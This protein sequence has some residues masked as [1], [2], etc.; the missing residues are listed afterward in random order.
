[1]AQ[2]PLNREER[3]LLWVSWITW[4]VSVGFAAWILTQ[5]LHKRGWCWFLLVESI[6]FLSFPFVAWAVVGQVIVDL[7]VLTSFALGLTL[8]YLVVPILRR[9]KQGEPQPA[10]P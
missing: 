5:Q 1:M 8:M 4:T 2:V 6:L 9:K 3:S 10:Q 7:R